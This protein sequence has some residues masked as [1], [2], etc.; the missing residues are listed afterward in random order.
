VVNGMEHLPEP[1]D[2]HRLFNEMHPLNWG[3]PIPTKAELVEE[4]GEL[5]TGHA[6]ENLA[7]IGWRDAAATTD[8][9]AL[10]TPDCELYQPDKRI[11]SPQSLARKIKSYTGRRQQ[12]HRSKTCSATPC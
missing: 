3:D 2:L 1:V 9:Q 8:V 5:A 6:L 10:V 11:K 4:F 7:A 12:H